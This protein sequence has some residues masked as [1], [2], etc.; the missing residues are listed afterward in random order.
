MRPDFPELY[1]YAL[2][3]G[4]LVTIFTNGTLV[5]DGIAELFDEYR[6][7]T[8]EISLYGMTRETY[9]K[10]TGIPGSYDKCIAGIERLVARGI[11]LTL[12]T[13]AL[14]WNQH[15]IGGDGGLRGLARASSSSSTAC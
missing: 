12:K 15:E 4:L 1:L 10:V 14:T 9:E 8:V 2:R 5:T 3:R 13:M 11:P 6:P 7:E